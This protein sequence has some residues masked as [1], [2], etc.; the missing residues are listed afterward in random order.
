MWQQFLDTIYDVLMAFSALGMLFTLWIA[1]EPIWD[2]ISKRVKARKYR[3]SLA[4]EAV[5][6]SNRRTK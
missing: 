2:A 1:V 4:S 6:K 5:P 3:R